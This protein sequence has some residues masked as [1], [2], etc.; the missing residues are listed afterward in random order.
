MVKSPEFRA[1]A[2]TYRRLKNYVDPG[3]PGRNWNDAVALVIQGKAGMHMMGDW[4]KGEFTAAGRTPG[5]DY[6]CFVLSN[7]GGGYVMGGDVFAFPKSK[8]ADTAEGP[9]SPACSC[10]PATVLLEP[11]DADRVLPEEGHPSRCARTWTSTASRSTSAPR[12][13]WPLSA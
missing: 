10:C 3:A 9:A 1:V 8:S 7:H 6:G 13:R 4:A 11:G 5:K 2:E 12:R